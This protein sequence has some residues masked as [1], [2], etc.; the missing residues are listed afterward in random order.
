MKYTQTYTQKNSHRVQEDQIL[1]FET[2]K[3]IANR[4]ENRSPDALIIYHLPHTHTEFRL[5]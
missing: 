4:L 1:P 5:M 2:D 3:M